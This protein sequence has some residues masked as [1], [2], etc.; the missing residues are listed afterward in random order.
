MSNARCS[1][2]SRARGG[3]FGPLLIIVVALA[4][5]AAVFF[6]FTKKWIEKE[7]P[8]P[9]GQASTPTAEAPPAPAAA[10]PTTAQDAEPAAAKKPAAPKTLGFARPQDVAQ[11]LT[12]NL[13]EGDLKSAAGLVA[14]GDPS[15]AAASLSVMEKI[16]E[17]GYKGGA[18]S[19]VQTLGQTEGVVRLSVP[20]SNTQ[21]GAPD[22]NLQIDVVKDPNM[23]WRVH[24]LRL[25]KELE[26]A[27]A[28][29]IPPG[30]P[31]INP[32]GGPPLPAGSGQSLFVVDAAPDA[33]T[34]AS[35]FVRALLKLDYET[36]QSYVDAD[37]IPPVK[38]A[39]LCIVFE[40]GKY[41]LQDQKPLVATV[42]TETSSWIIAKVRSDIYKEETE[43][44]LEM[45][46]N[47]RWLAHHR[48]KSLPPPRGQRP[49]LGI[50]RHSL[51]SAGAESQR[52][53]KHRPVL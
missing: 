25:P 27:V 19:L 18:V 44:G 28:A 39:G 46:K 41:A 23:G 22:L 14:A 17:L 30:A 21:G 50:G 35:N 36:A 42:S 3:A 2:R 49:L 29:V 11:Q 5:S 15:Q 32:A 6:L 53:R 33:I 38:L 10:R 52:G 40:D 48:P 26:I 16:K 4:M 51:H 12:R 13:A 34:H 47:C 24:K 31:M 7:T 43:F 9:A 8:A 1:I 45:E 37:K 20:L